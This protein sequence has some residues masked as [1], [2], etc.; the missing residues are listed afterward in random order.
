MKYPYKYK[1]K[2]V[3]ARKITE[4]CEVSL[5]EMLYTLEFGKDN[6]LDKLI[7]LYEADSVD[8][9]KSIADKSHLLLVM[10]VNPLAEHWKIYDKYRSEIVKEHENEL[11]KLKNILNFYSVSHNGVEDTTSDNR[12][13]NWE[14]YEEYKNG[15]LSNIVKEYIQK[16]KNYFQEQIKKFT[17]DSKN[18]LKILPQKKHDAEVKFSERTNEVNKIVDY[19]PIDKTNEYVDLLEKKFIDIIGVEKLHKIKYDVSRIKRLKD[20]NEILYKYVNNNYLTGGGSSWFL[21]IEGIVKDWENDLKETENIE[22]IFNDIFKQIS[23]QDPSF[24]SF[25]DFKENKFKNVEKEKF[26][27]PENISD[28]KNELK[29]LFNKYFES[30]SQDQ[31]LQKIG[32]LIN[33][34]VFSDQNLEF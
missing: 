30:H 34:V 4:F 18:F 8:R 14:Y 16:I 3:E 2:D 1:I 11:F 7:H 24:V 23:T 26:K 25:K 33:N 10:K 27:Q 13:T 6:P 21:D 32:E 9:E 22:H 19:L 12:G 5:S 29:F 20:N 31:E 15:K 28:Q 17:D